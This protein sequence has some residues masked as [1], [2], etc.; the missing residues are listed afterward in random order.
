MGVGDRAVD[1]DFK[2]WFSVS[3]NYFPCP[4]ITLLLRTLTQCWRASGLLCSSVHPS[5]A[6]FP[7]PS[8]HN[9]VKPGVTSDLGDST[10]YLFPGSF[11]TMEKDLDVQMAE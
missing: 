2:E 7:L 6:L 9:L 1:H 4:V 8:A 5:A 11:I 10:V 3:L